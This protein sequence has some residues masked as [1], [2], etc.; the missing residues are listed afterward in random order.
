[1]EYIIGLGGNLGDPKAT[2]AE[3]MELVSRH[4][5]PIISRSP[6]YWTKPMLHPVTPTLGQSPHLNA[7]VVSDSELSAEQVLDELLHLE[8]E[9]GRVRASEVVPWGP[10]VIDL[11]LIAAEQLSL[12][13][14]R[15]SVP[16]AEMHNRD[17]VLVPMLSVVPS[18]RHPLLDKT[19]AELEA[20]LTE[21]WIISEDTDEAQARS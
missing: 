17:F 15:L 12:N 7:V 10:R 1:M 6:L 20:E 4:I 11:D 16:H 8:E 9:L 19:V 5:G 14:P 21:R 18:W 13:S 2:L 3:A